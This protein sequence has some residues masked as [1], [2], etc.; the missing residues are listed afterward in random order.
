MELQISDLPCATMKIRNSL[1]T[2]TRFEV[3]ADQLR[4]WK[5]A[6]SFPE[7]QELNIIEGD[8]LEEKS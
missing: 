5:E 8:N 4:S 3:D 1:W 7:K 6:P 2:L